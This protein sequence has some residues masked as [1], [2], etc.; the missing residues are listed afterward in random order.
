MSLKMILVTALLLMNSIIYNL[1]FSFRNRSFRM[2]KLVNFFCVFLGSLK[3][4]IKD[5]SKKRKQ[6]IKEG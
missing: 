3:Q 5:N 6:I 4:I 2:E 1:V